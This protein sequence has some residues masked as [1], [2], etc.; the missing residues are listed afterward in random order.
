M[1]KQKIIYPSAR[2]L[3]IILS[4][5]VRKTDL[6]SFLRAKGIFFFNITP[7]ELSE[8][9]SEMLLTYDE[10]EQIRSLAY[11]STNKQILNGFSLVSNGA[12]DLSDIYNS[13]RNQGVINSDG[14]KL[15]SIS[16]KSTET[17]IIYEGSITYTQKTAGRIE[18]IRC[19]E[20]DVF[21]VMK[22]IDDKHWQ[23]EVDG[24]KSNDGKTVFNMLEKLVKGKNISVNML[25]IDNLTKTETITFFDRLVKEGLDKNWSIEDIERITLKQN[26]NNINESLEDEEVT[27]E[28]L[29]GI[30]QAIL[31][32]KNLR[33]NSFVKQAE[34]SGY[35]F[36][37]MTYTFS[38]NKESKTIKIRAE[39]KGN[40]KIFEV[41]LESYMEPSTD[42][43]DKLEETLS[44][45]NDK[46]NM[47]IR[48]TF[49]NNA[50]IIYD[51][52]INNRE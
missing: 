6:L 31:E 32:G 52:I 26:V 47:N 33:E 7:N 46:E 11:R 12:F 44:N 45:L 21:F 34:D 49:W 8:K 22:S 2:D 18:F 28:Q 40:P 51:N 42:N 39:F 25:R 17:G 36:T 30:T 16:K 35:A 38:N 3:K 13:I 10:L 37:S 15:N 9:F 1:N 41:C 29:S 27:K 4:D 19:E 24:G 48:S 23:I 50:K 20:R 14:Y 43:K 5:C